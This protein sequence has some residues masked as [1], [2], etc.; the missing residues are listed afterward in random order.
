M[1]SKNIQHQIQELIRRFPTLQYNEETNVIEGTLNVDDIDEDIYQVKIDISHF[2]KYFPQVWETGERIPRKP[3]RHIYANSN[4]LCF[5]TRAKEMILLRKK[6]K[7]I[8]CFVSEILI[9]YLQNNSYYEINGT[10]RDGEYDHGGKGVLQGYQD[11]LGLKKPEHILEALDWR[12]KGKKAT[13]NEPCFCGNG[14]IKNCHL[15]RYKK[16][17]WISPETIYEDGIKII[18]LIK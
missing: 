15:S 9:K 12:M 3:D 18:D 13:R 11:I 7:T 16:L 4:S 6:V 17:F 14:K 1:Q 8:H 5:T 2:P 10:Y